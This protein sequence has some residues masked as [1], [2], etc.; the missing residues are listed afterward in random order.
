M[1]EPES[2][3][4]VLLGESGVGKTSIISQFINNQFDPHRQISSNS[5]LNNKIIEFPEYNKSLKYDI[6]DTVGQEQYR[7]LAKIFFK[8]ADV[9][10]FVYDISS[11]FSFNAIQNYWYPE[12]KNKADKDPI[13]VLV[14]NKSDLFKD[15]KISQN[16]GK[17][18][19]EQI[20]AIYIRTSALSNM[21]INM[22]F[23]SIGKKIITKKYSIKINDD[24]D[25]LI[26]K[27]INEEK[28]N[29]LFK[30]NSFKLKDNITSSN[31][32]KRIHRKKKCCK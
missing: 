15:E 10:I 31:E 16:E 21:E 11:S 17:I 27:D 19:A 7:S 5:Q 26:L 6:W 32:G 18:F 23:E 9:I 30:K 25:N 8:N 20:N 12:T 28:D 3:K 22:L 4:V 29:K 1:D 24:N 13:L 14:A 2:I